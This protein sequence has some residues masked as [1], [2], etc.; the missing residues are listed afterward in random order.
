M[1]MRANFIVAKHPS[2]EVQAGVVAGVFPGRPSFRFLDP[3]DASEPTRVAGRATDREMVGTGV[4][5]AVGVTLL[6]AA[7]V[8]SSSRMPG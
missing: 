5:E 4:V 3:G 7:A 6:S 1:P 8:R 2:Y